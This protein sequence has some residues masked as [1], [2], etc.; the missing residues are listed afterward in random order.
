MLSPMD[1]V[2]DQFNLLKE[3]WIPVLWNYANDLFLLLATVE[4]GLAGL[5]WVVQ[6]EGA[7]NIGAGLLRKFLWLGFM[8]AVLFHADT[9]I[10]AI[11]R[12]FMIAGQQAAHIDTLDPGEVFTSG[13]GIGAKMLWEMTGLGLLTTPT[14][15]LS[16]L[17][18]A[19]IV[20]FAFG[21]IA[22]EM[23]ITLI[24][25]YILTGAG[26]F[27]LGFAA[28]RGTASIS[29]RYLSFT[30]GVGLKLFVIYLLVGAGALL[31]PEWGKLINQTSMLDYKVP[32]TVAFAALMYAAVA[33]RIPQLAGTLASGT[34]AMSFH[35]VMG[36]TV[37]ATR[38]AAS[39]GTAAAT[40]G[41]GA[42][43][44]GATARLG[45]EKA[46]ASGGGVMGG[47]KGG[48]AAGSALTSEAAQ[49]AVPRLNRVR[50]NIASRVPG[51]GN[52]GGNTSENGSST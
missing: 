26:V 14:G 43:T 9:W 3:L 40:A 13:L 19:L 25:S 46:Q 45:I 27:M 7:E 21:I 39:A 51:P 50:Q 15:V 48:W 20:I 2:P 47:L 49:A 11:F 33:M 37:M 22:I 36:A 44:F 32:F 18:A 31:A 52:S 6:R 10:P 16:G 17:V 42:A 41:V 1:S 5:L 8:Y 24:E 35:D 38:M 29:E 12:S 28:F 23:A 34:V 30:I 4:I